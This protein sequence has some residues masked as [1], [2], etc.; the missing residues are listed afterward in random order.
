MI[1]MVITYAYIDEDGHIKVKLS[2]SMTGFQPV[3]TIINQTS[4]ADS[5]NHYAVTASKDGDTKNYSRSF[6]IFVSQQVFSDYRI[7]FL[8]GLVWGIEI[9][10]NENISASDLKSMKKDSE[11]EIKHYSLEFQS[12]FNK[13]SNID[14][15]LYSTQKNIESLEKQVNSTK[16]V[17][18]FLAALSLIFI[19]LSS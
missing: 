9:E 10:M 6:K 11:L 2:E 5:K 15:K 19:L 4:A 16:Q 12:T 17:L 7:F 13:L 1:K 3:L 8:M 14:N 18:Y